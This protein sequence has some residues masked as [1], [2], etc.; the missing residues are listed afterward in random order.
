MSESGRT[1]RTLSDVRPTLANGRKSDVPGKLIPTAFDPKADIARPPSILFEPLRCLPASRNEHEAARVHYTSWRRCGAC[2]S[3]PAR[4]ALAADQQGRPDRI[5]GFR[6]CRRV[7]TIGG[8][9]P[10]WPAR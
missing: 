9:P 7:R 10:D 6:D 3:L 8:G 4:G 1:Q 2:D 5:S